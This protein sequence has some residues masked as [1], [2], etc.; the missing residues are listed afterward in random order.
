[1]CTPNTCFPPKSISQTLSR[2]VQPFLRSSWQNVPILYNGLSLSPSKLPLHMGDLDLHLIHASLGLFHSASQTASRPVQP[3]LHS[4]RQRVPVVYNRPPLPLKIAPCM[5]QYSNTW[6]LYPPS[7][8][9]KR[10]LNRF[11][12]FAGLMMVTDRQT[13]LNQ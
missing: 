3:F 9:A 11:N 5:G 12:I 6:F 1:V 10:H 2:S 7:P 8:Q 13:T 4:S